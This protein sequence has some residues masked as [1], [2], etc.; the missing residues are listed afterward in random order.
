MPSAT[1]PPA[2]ASRRRRKGR[3]RLAALAND[4]GDVV[5]VPNAHPALVGPA[6]FA[7][8]QERFAR[9]K[10]LTTPVRGGPW[11][12]TGL[13]RCGECGG[14][15]H[16][17]Q[18][19]S[20]A[21]SALNDSMCERAKLKKGKGGRKRVARKCVPQS[22]LLDEVV[23]EIRAWFA[24]GRAREALRAAVQDLAGR[25]RENARAEQ[26]RLQALVA[27]LDA[28]IAQRSHGELC[29]VGKS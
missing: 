13:L 7:A 18:S 14:P 3:R 1:T 21:G 17:I 19:T 10:A 16:G 9:N 24:T 4:A 12:L 29:E 27:D 28:K 25:G 15:L 23:E 20:T 2:C 8:V 26:A 6:T 11:L 22:L 5:E